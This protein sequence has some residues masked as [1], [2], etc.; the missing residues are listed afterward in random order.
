MSSGQAPVPL[1]FDLPPANPL[2]N[3][4]DI[5]RVYTEFLDDDMVAS[6][7][8]LEEQTSKRYYI[9]VFAKEGY[10]L[11]KDCEHTQTVFEPI[12]LLLAGF[13][14][15]VVSVLNFPIGTALGM[16]IATSWA[17]VIGLLIGAVGF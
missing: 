4:K 17:P 15:L 9:G 12:R 11:L 5:S 13:L 1:T 16:S 10:Y 14:V 2:S 8:P 7:Q 3:L 6:L